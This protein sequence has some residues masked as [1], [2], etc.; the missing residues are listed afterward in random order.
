M[1]AWHAED[2]SEYQ[3]TG[4][5]VSPSCLRC[6][7]PRCKHDDPHGVRQQ[8]QQARDLERARIIQAE[9]LTAAQAAERFGVA[10]RTV[11]RILERCR[12]AAGGLSNA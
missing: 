11:F 4:C 8:R 3:D 5:E 6:P 2:G 9:G 1:T 7:L 10:E 12:D